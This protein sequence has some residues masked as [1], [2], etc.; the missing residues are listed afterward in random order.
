M[1]CEAHPWPALPVAGGR[2]EGPETMS[3][4]L[5]RGSP[6][7]MLPFSCCQGMGSYNIFF[8]K[9]LRTDAEL[10]PSLPAASFLEE[11]ATIR[12]FLRRLKPRGFVS[13]TEEHVEDWMVA[14]LGDLR[15]CRRPLFQ[16]LT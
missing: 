1:D 15:R 12:E 10:C 3:A 6:F 16:P 2:R 9:V 8:C 5:Y 4:W 7:L 13:H 11:N 14:V